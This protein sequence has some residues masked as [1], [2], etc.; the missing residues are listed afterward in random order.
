[1]RHSWLAGTVLFFL[2]CTAAQ[3]HYLWIEK[4]DGVARV[5][6]GE[7]AEDL[8]EDDGKVMKAVQGITA[9]NADRSP[10][11]LRREFNHFL[12]EKP[13][14]G[15]IRVFDEVMHRGSK[16][17]YE[18]KYGRTETRPAM[19]FE[20]VP[21]AADGNTLVLMLEGKP[22]P[23]AEVVVFGPPKWEKHFTTDDK[24]Q[25]TIQTPW[26][27]QYVIRVQSDDETTGEFEG[28][29]FDKIINVAI[30]SFDVQE[31]VALK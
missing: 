9:F 25:V 21:T 7:W 12:V 29:K 3:A 17:V 15:D 26:A 11:T 19:N 28:K 24:G 30:L 2:S 1:M 8:R 13:G 18:V 10:V 6:F 23:K 14:S 20:L 4:V 5:Y 27:G 22:L 31:A 16:V